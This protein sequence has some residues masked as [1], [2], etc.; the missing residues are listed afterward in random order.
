MLSWQ[1]SNA[2]SEARGQSEL[3]KLHILSVLSHRKPEEEQQLLITVFPPQTAIAD[4]Q[5]NDDSLLDLHFGRSEFAPVCFR[6][7]VRHP[8]TSLHAS[9]PNNQASVL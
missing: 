7:H 2:A 8:Y 4:S 3:Q 1:S 6:P 9:I 5:L